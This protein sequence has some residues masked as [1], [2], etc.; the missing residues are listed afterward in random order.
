M[1]LKK[2]ILLFILISGS[3]LTSQ[4]KSA[5]Q[6]AAAA[7]TPALVVLE[8]D[9]PQLAAVKEPSKAR[10]QEI[11]KDMRAIH[12]K[13][14]DQLS[15]KNGNW[16]QEHMSKSDRSR[17]QGLSADLNSELD[18]MRS[19]LTRTLRADRMAMADLM[20]Q[21]L[22]GLGATVRG[23]ILL[24]N[25]IAIT[26]SRPLLARIAKLPGVARVELDRPMGHLLD[27]SMATA[28]H[29]TWWA[30]GYDGSGLDFGIVDGGVDESHPAFSHILFHGRPGDDFDDHGT[31]VAGTVIMD[32]NGLLGGASGVNSVIWANGLGSDSSY[33]MAID[34]ITNG[35]AA[36]PE[37]LNSSLGNPMI[38][39]DDT[40]VE[41]YMDAYVDVYGIQVAQAAGNSGWS[42][43]SSTLI[44]PARAYNSLSVA[45]MDDQNTTNRA[46]DVR[47]SSSSVGPTPGG[48]RKPDL[49]APGTQ[50]MASVTNNGYAD[51][52]GT[53]MAS[54]HV[55]AA[56][57][58]LMDGGNFEPI[59]QKAVLIN[60]AEPWRS[61]NTSSTSDD[62]PSHVGAW[63]KS[64]GWGYLDMNRAAQQ[65]DDY[66]TGEVWPK[67]SANGDDF[68]LYKLSMDHYDRATL[69]WNRHAYFFFFGGEPSAV[70]YAL[71]DLGLEL[72]NEGD[73]SLLYSDDT[74]MD[75]VHQVHN[76]IYPSA[77]VVVKVFANS[78]EFNAVD[79]EYYALA[80]AGCQ[81]LAPSLSANWRAIQPFVHPLDPVIF[82]IE[83]FNAGEVAAHNNT[84]VVDYGRT[85]II[86]AD[87]NYGPKELET[88]PARSGI[89]VK[90]AVIADVPRGSYQLPIRVSS[91]SYGE[92]FTLNQSITVEVPRH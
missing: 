61:Y 47:R 13:Y 26:A 29:T 2:G 21:R 56:A 92:Q 64:Y 68:Q 83:I 9:E 30:W 25:A 66:C 67:G 1:F 80:G 63:D 49:C 78:T 18:A 75:N 19:E 91:K 74:L 38:S 65:K 46:D 59:T 79:K 37:V 41:A 52:S 15:M 50:I 4:P 24:A 28:G 53:S 71:N 44:S 40:L 20:S 23:R 35:A 16:G 77:E 73:N 88:I 33:M 82:L 48:R 22:E 7:G 69:V 10:L 62:G 32:G 14:Q 12:H 89:V 72:Y 60:T 5:S 51:M 58:L 31:H 17:L 76:P 54:P 6:G 86:P 27:V 87:G 36:S 84:L 34:W 39:S 8:G 85:G 81:K 90:L 42:S 45:N 11:A 3:F 57:L 70:P 43:T 55:A